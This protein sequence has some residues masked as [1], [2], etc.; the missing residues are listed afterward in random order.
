MYHVWVSFDKFYP[1]N[2]YG[3][4]IYV[5]ADTGEINYVKERVSTTDPQT[6]LIATFDEANKIS[7]NEFNKDF[8][9]DSMQL[10]LVS[11]LLF[12]L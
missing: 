11:L 4:N 5:W 10:M 12:L 7:E 9:S 6:D 8:T 2:I 1:G 3:M